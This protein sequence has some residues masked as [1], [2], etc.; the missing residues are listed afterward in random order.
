M[1]TI[2]NG[3]IINKWNSFKYKIRLFFIGILEKI[4]IKTESLIFF[5][6]AE[7]CIIKKEIFIFLENGTRNQILEKE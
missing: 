7:L 1:L 2:N 6:T 3:F 5:Q 4:D